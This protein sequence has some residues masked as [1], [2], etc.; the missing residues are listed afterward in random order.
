M[1]QNKISEELDK[2]DEVT[3]EIKAIVF[4]NVLA[5][6]AKKKTELEISEVITRA[7]KNNPLI[8]KTAAKS[9][10]ALAQ[11]IYFRLSTE[12]RSLLDTL[13][14][15]VK[16][17]VPSY[18]LDFKALVDLDEGD[19]KTGGSISISGVHFRNYVTSADIAVPLIKDYAIKV[20]EVY[21]E[22]AL[23]EPKVQTSDGRA[24]NLRSRAEMK[25]RHEAIQEDI[26]ELKAKGEHYAYISS[27]ANASKRCAPWQGKLVDL[28]APAKSGDGR[29]GESIAGESVYSL[30]YLERLNDGNSILS[31]YNCRH[32][33]IPFNPDKSTN[34]KPKHFSLD[35]MERER[36]I[37]NTKARYENQIRKLKNL[38]LTV[39]EAGA[40]SLEKRL[41]RARD[42]YREFCIKNH[43]EINVNRLANYKIET[44]INR[45]VVK[46][47]LV[48]TAVTNYAIGA[49]ETLLLKQKLAIEATKL[50]DLLKRDLMN[51]LSRKNMS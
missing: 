50:A 25:V 24:I 48:K 15:E 18:T 19:L 38:R 33:L 2:I 4:E 26:K 29:T 23:E 13:K 40:K 10:A 6:K 27:H 51:R 11:Q 49:A 45:Y 1:D 12:L 22:L 30:T 20:R 32:Y 41:K 37:D 39:D 31:G 34:A 21:K 7:Q 17:I 35:Q 8:D 36:K 46:Q 3:A 16:K 28:Q 47:D 5:G 9:L 44:K 43:R 14:Y 42:T